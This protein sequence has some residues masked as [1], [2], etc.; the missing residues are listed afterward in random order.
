[1][2]LVE[3]APLLTA[4][5]VLE[6]ARHEQDAQTARALQLVAR[7]VLTAGMPLAA[8]PVESLHKR[9]SDRDA[10]LGGCTGLYL[11]DSARHVRHLY[12]SLCLEVPAGFEAM[13]DH[14][15]LLIELLDVYTQAGNI[16]AARQLV[17]DHFDWLGSY[18]RRL[19]ARA[20]Q[21]AEAPLFDATTRALLAA[22]IAWLRE[23]VARIDELARAL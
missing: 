8:L 23:I 20:A 15:A 13:P 16:T 7:E 18:D 22:G 1:M 19:E 2:P 6:H 4:Q 3:L 5:G 12:G 14:L 10:A 9:W 21:A 11:G 17:A